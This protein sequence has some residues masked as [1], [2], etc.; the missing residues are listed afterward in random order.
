MADP[1]RRPDAALNDGVD[2]VSGEDLEA[3]ECDNSFYEMYGEMPDD[4][5]SYESQE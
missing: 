1:Q 4:R 5:T 2:P 3:P